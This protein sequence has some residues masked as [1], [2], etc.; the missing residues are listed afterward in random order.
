MSCPQSKCHERR[1][2]MSV[3][4]VESNMTSYQEV[5]VITSDRQRWRRRGGGGGGEEVTLPRRV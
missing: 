4:K 2:R 1:K 5:K 3:R